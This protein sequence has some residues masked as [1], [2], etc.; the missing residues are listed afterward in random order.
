MKISRASVRSGAAFTLIEL[1]VVVMIIATLAGFMFPAI[2][3]VLTNAKKA[4]AKNDMAQIESSI[5]WY[6][7]EYGQY[8]ITSTDQAG[9]D[10][11]CIYGASTS[12][13]NEQIIN[14]LRYPVNGYPT[15]WTDANSLNTR[16]IRFLEAKVNTTTKGAVNSTTGKWFDPWGKEYIILID[17]DY[18]GDI[19]LSTVLTGTPGASATG[20][21]QRGVGV[22]C[23]GFYSSKHPG[24]AASYPRTFVGNQDLLSWQ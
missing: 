20:A 15:G 4:V 18:A 13:G 23:V 21:V 7:N 19:N 1:L 2:Q 8:P 16:Q 24:Q 10:A 11:G 17:G 3:N 14:I 9:G 5:K 6:Y 22:I 12:K